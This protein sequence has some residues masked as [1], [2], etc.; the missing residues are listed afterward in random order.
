MRHPD[1]RRSLFADALEEIALVVDCEL[2]STV[3][4]MF[5]FCH[6]SAGEMRHQLHAIT[7]TENGNP[8]IE[9]FFGH[10]RRLFLVHAG[11]TT[12]KHETLGAI[13]ENGPQR[14]G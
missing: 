14:K 8:Q 6:L 2:R 3:L 9:E 13:G 11:W 4:T 1:N 5:G 12:G 7:D 10:A